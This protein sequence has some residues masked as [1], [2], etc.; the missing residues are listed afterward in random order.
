MFY[1]EFA[2]IYDLDRNKCM[3][4]PSGKKRIQAN[5]E[6]KYL[7][8][9]EDFKSDYQELSEEDRINTALDDAQLKRSDL[10]TP[11]MNALILKY[12]KLQTTRI[13]KLLKSGYIMVDNLQEFFTTVNFKEKDDNGKLVHS[14]KEAMANLASLGKTVYGLDALEYQ[15]KKQMEAD[16]GIRGDASPGYY[17]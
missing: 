16:K 4:D 14:A 10:D 6:F 3:K 8:L 13:M 1:K 11:E 17:D 2:A 7:W 15:V 5:K 9:A 12:R